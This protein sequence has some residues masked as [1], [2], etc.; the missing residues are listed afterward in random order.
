MDIS[1][2]LIWK[3]IVSLHFQKLLGTMHLGLA[4]SP[5]NVG[6]SFTLPTKKR[7]GDHVFY[8]YQEPCTC[9]AHDTMFRHPTSQYDSAAHIRDLAIASLAPA[10]SSLG[11]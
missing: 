4:L 11:N 5:L 2:F 8:S 1:P 3:D 10:K 9:L 6:P 7:K